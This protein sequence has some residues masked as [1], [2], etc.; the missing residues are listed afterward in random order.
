MTAE[1]MLKRKIAQQIAEVKEEIC[2]FLRHGEGGFFSQGLVGEVDI[3]KGISL[4]SCLN[5]GIP[6]KGLKRVS[7]QLL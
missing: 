4:C 5:S 2:S 1:R 6:P 3:G 7:I